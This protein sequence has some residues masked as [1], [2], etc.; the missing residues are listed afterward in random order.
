MAVF[1][2]GT[3]VI[4]QDVR[5]TDKADRIVAGGA[6]AAF[7]GLLINPGNEVRWTLA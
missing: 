5:R 7:P 6:L 1:V 4:T 2:H 3:R